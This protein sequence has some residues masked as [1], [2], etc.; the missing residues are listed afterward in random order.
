M[1]F[2]NENFTILGAV[3]MR[4]GVTDQFAFA[5][6]KTLSID[7]SPRPGAGS[8]QGVD[9]DTKVEDY[10]SKGWERGGKLEAVFGPQ[11]GR[12][13]LR[14]AR[15]NDREVPDPTWAGRFGADDQVLIND[16]IGHYFAPGRAA[17][18]TG[19]T[20]DDFRH[21]SHPL[22]PSS[23]EEFEQS[24]TLGPDKK[25]AIRARIAAQVKQDAEDMKLK[26]KV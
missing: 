5:G 13:F 17:D 24:T 23:R 6:I 15:E 9:N 21:R 2:L 25:Q 7:I 12:G 22:H 16:A 14:E 18:G 20:D 1:S 4:S 11:Y 8:A 10:P 3:G 19:A 26:S